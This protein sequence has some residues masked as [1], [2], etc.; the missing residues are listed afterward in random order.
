MSE[1]IFK[2]VPGRVSAV[3]RVGAVVVLVLCLAWVVALWSAGRGDVEMSRLFGICG[4]KQAYRMPCPGC[5]VT[6]SSIAF[7]QGRLVESFN[8]Q[9]AGA[10]LCLGLIAVGGLSV[11]VGFFGKNFGFLHYPGA[12][13]LLKYVVISALIVFACGWAV[14]F[15]RTLAGR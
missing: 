4:F 8:T 6:T 5:G 7:F 3:H 1:A 2:S 10:V 14:T 11:M 15:S 9:P 13:R 12:V